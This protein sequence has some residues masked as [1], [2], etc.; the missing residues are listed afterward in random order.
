MFNHFFL[1]K[2]RAF[3]ETMWKNIVE[4]G[5][6]QMTIWRMRI[7]CWITKATNTNLECV[8][9][10]AFPLQKWLQESVS[11]LYFTNIDCLISY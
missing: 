8:L 9:L 6:P 1:K 10:I 7:V 2:N 3:Y 11:V 4:P 5:I